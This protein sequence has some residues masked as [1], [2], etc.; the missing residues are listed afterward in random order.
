[1]VFG[2]R[3]VSEVLIAK[4]EN[5]LAGVFCKEADNVMVRI[6]DS[7][8]VEFFDSANTTDAM[9]PL[10]VIFAPTFACSAPTLDAT[11]DATVG[12]PTGKIFTGS[13]EPTRVP[14]PSEPK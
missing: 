5:S 11:G 9:W 3:S 13:F 12:V 1:M 10:G 4:D 2:S 6:V 7:A 8:S 14:C